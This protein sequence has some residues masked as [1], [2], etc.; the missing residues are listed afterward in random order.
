MRIGVVGSMQYTEKMMELRDRLAKM[1][2]DAFL[3]NLASPFIGKSD[4]EKEK[5]KIHQKQNKDAI[6]EFWRLMQG[7]DAILVANFD[8]NGVKN[9]IGGNTLMEIGFAHVLNQKIF[10][11]NPIPEIPYYKTEIEAVKPILL[12]GDLALIL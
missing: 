10:L 8:K 4:K 3:T 2:H 12:N 11:L 5:I 6:R 1:G 9:Y 7:A